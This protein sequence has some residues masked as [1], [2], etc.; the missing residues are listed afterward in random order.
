MQLQVGFSRTFFAVLL[1]SRDKR[2][3][4]FPSF[5]IF[6]MRTW[7][8]LFLGMC[9]GMAPSHAAQLTQSNNPVT[10][11]RSWK[12][13]DRGISIEFIQLTPEAAQ[14]TYSTRDLSPAIYETMRG[15]CFFGSVVRNEADA[16][17]TYKVAD[18]RVVNAKGK[19][20]KL[21]TKTEWVNEW[22]KKGGRF[23]WSILPDDITLEVGDWALGYTP[24]QVAAG[25]QFDLIYVWSQ[26][27]KTFTGVLPHVECYAAPAQ[28]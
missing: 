14:A 7:L 6:S 20:L 8:G 9:A 19:K 23:A 5:L 21:R 15:Y 26:N 28:P 4:G 25:E 10:G 27:G 18:W 3:P 12:Q 22:R 11:L 1:C 17:L 24:V 2:P 16:P 13:S